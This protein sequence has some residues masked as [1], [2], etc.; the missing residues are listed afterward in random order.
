MSQCQCS[1]AT[2][3]HP[4]VSVFECKRESLD[5]VISFMTALHPLRPSLIPQSVTKHA[6]HS[7]TGTTQQDSVS[8][9]HPKDHPEA[10]LQPYECHARER[11]VLGSIGHHRSSYVQISSSFLDALKLGYLGDWE[12]APAFVRSRS[13]TYDG[14]AAHHRQL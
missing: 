12:F 4:F 5:I 9:Y 10:R 14:Y 2:K 3:E 13:R 6:R 1:I 8:Q 7:Y 11:K